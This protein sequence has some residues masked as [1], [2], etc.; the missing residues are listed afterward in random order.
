MELSLS[1][2]YLLAMMGEDQT[3][4]NCAFYGTLANV[5]NTHSLYVEGDHAMLDHVSVYNTYNHGI[6]IK[7]SD[8]DIVSP[9]C[10]SNY[11]NITIRADIKDVDNVRI[12]SP[13]IQKGAYGLLLQ[14]DVGYALTDITIDDAIIDELSVAGVY[15]RSSGVSTVDTVSVVS[16]VITDSAVGITFDSQDAGS[17]VTNCLAIA[18]SVW[19]VSG[20]GIVATGSGTSDVYVIDYWTDATTPTAGTFA[21][22]QVNRQI[23]IYTAA[24]GAAHTNS[25]AE[26]YGSVIYVTSAATITLPSVAVGMSLTVCTVGG[27]AVSVDPADADKIVLDGTALHD[28]DKVTNLST[29]GDI[30][31]FTY[32]SADGWYAASNGWTD[33]G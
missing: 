23:P 19:T 31:V 30:V 20:T 24:Y 26:C 11:Y 1:D 8:V 6:A 7:A 2:F 10:W 25:A 9:Y 29:A 16:P 32:Y 13:R 18:P 4:R 33:G 12:T 3:V 5:T 28:G 22:S 21:Y 14:S 27:I 17:L 15:I